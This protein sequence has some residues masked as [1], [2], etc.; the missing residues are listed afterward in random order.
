MQSNTNK[1]FLIG[2]FTTLLPLY[3]KSDIQVLQEL[4]LLVSEDL[5]MMVF[6]E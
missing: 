3:M 1:H 2:L 6:Y 4:Y 5:Q